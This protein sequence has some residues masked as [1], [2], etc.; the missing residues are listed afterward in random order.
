M[1]MIFNRIEH[2]ERK[3]EK[4]EAR[5][6]CHKKSQGT[7]RQNKALGGVINAKWACG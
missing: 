6:F 7:Q 5:I 4:R 1:G 3:G 2:K